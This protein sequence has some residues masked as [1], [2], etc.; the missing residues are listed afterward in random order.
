MA[1]GAGLYLGS[2]ADTSMNR[3]LLDG[4]GGGWPESVL[5][6]PLRISGRIVIILYAESE[7]DMAEHVPELQKLMSKTA[8]AFE[9]LICRE[10]ILML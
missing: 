4:I 6:A 2:L 8:L 7:K 1:D 5:L 10:K 3:R 9:A